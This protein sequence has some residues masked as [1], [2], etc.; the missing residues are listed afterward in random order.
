MWSGNKKATPEEW[1]WKANA[2]RRLG[3]RERHSLDGL[4]ELLARLELD[5]SALGD[6]HG[7]L[8]LVGVATHTGLAAL[9]LENA[10]VA[11]LDVT[12][13]G[14]SLQHD[15][16]RHLDGFGDLL[17]GKASFFVDRGDDF[18]FCEVGHVGWC[19]TRLNGAF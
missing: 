5:D 8:G 16:E 6:D 11:Q 19:L 14:E 18:A 15:V 9:N 10:E 12:A 3:G 4:L 2:V 17:L 7:L 1:L 13:L